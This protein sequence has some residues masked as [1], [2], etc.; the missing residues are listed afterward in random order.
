MQDPYRARVEQVYVDDPH[1][2]KKAIGPSLLFHL[3]TYSAGACSLEEAGR[4]FLEQQ[5][6]LSSVKNPSRILDIGCGWGGV[7]EHLAGRFP[8]CP[9]LDGV[10][11]SRQQ[12]EY[13]R[14]RLNEA[15]LDDR[16]RLY[17][18]N[19]QDIARLPDPDVGYDLALARG[20][21]AHFPFPVLNA[22]AAGLGKRV[23]AGG[24][25]VVADVFY[26][27]LSTYASPIRDLVDRCGCK[28][29]KAV[30]HV[31]EA[32]EQNGFVLQDVRVL[33]SD[34]DT[35]RWFRQVQH[36]IDNHWPRQR[37]QALDEYYVTFSNMTAAIQQGAVSAYSIIARKR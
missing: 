15:S 16:L 28:Y 4:E 14:G 35:I 17:L 3:G 2:W 7:L 27:D 12:L 34:E 37:P 36:N 24:T 29:R 23:R 9:R 25:V 5:L 31:T 22:M 19:A 32:L 30:R 11:I 13:A 18:C 20:S 1:V 26:N 8:A 10:N 6:A 33:P 21:V